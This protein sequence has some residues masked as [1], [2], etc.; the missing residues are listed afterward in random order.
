MWP[1][2]R[3][4][5]IGQTESNWIF[6]RTPG[7]DPIQNADPPMGKTPS[8][9]KAYIR[10]TFFVFSISFFLFLRFQ[11]ESLSLSKKAIFGSLL[12]PL[13][14]LSTVASSGCPAK[15][16]TSFDGFS[17]PGHR[18]GVLFSQIDV[19]L[20]E[21]KLTGFRF[22]VF[23]FFDFLFVV[24]MVLDS[25]QICVFLS[26]IFSQSFIVHTLVIKHD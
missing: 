12:P 11:R 10:P 5:G 19:V 25:D 13:L 24:T 14:A 15:K 17:P 23:L 7:L 6:A 8:F 21:S 22:R 4:T 16:R 9:R 20:Y 3:S 18:F 1:R 26:V 2:G